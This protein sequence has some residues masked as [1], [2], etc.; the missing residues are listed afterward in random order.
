MNNKE[1]EIDK[2]VAQL[3]Q[4]WDVDISNLW[5]FRDWIHNL[6]HM[7]G[8]D[9][10]QNWKNTHDLVANCRHKMVIVTN[11]LYLQDEF[12]IERYCSECGYKEIRFEV[13]HNGQLEPLTDWIECKK[14]E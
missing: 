1:Q 7:P 6:D 3:E 5:A 14:V 9:E 2:K 12:L 4:S 10:I 13:Y 11:N 8:L